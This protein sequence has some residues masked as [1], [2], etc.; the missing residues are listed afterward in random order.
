MKGGVDA[1]DDVCSLHL[2]TIVLQAQ[3]SLHVLHNI[4]LTLST[5]TREQSR[6]MQCPLLRKNIA[7][8]LETSKVIFT[9][10]MSYAH[11]GA[12]PSV[13]TTPSHV[14][15]YGY[16]L[17]LPEGHLQQWYPSSFTDPTYPHVRF[18]TAEHYIM[19]RKAVAMDDAETANRIATTAATPAEARRM[20]RE[21]RGFKPDVWRGMVEKVAEEGNWLKFSQVEEC[22]EALLGTG[23]KVLAEASPEDR[24]WGIG[25]R[26]DEAEGKEAEWG[27][28][29]LGKALMKVRDRLRGEGM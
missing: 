28:N 23:D 4:R 19:Y 7:R 3:L 27:R 5:C 20:G 6:Y 12:P 18:Q 10:T 8:Q 1:R 15:F 16:E 25:F 26:G 29:L 21:V 11:P 9:C 22:R 17:Q 24:I 14:F 13:I 2:A